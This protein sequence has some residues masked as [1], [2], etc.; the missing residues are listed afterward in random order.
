MSIV[1]AS[2]LDSPKLIF[3]FAGERSIGQTGDRLRYFCA[4]MRQMEKR[5]VDL[6]V[7]ILILVCD[8]AISSYHLRLPGS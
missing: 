5:R 3:L 4:K 2:P 7:C 8:E 6:G 1:N